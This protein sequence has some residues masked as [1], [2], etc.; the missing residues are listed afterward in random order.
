MSTVRGAV[1]KTE[2][3]QKLGVSSA[4][5]SA[6]EWTAALPSI[7]AASH[8]DG[9][10]TVAEADELVSVFEQR[11]RRP[12]DATY[13]RRF[14]DST[15]SAW[16][17]PAIFRISTMF[18]NITPASPPDVAGEQAARKRRS[19][20]EKQLPNLSLP[21]EAQLLTGEISAD[22]FASALNEIL[23]EVFDGDARG[24]AK[25]IGVETLDFAKYRGGFVL[26]KSYK[27]IVAIGDRLKKVDESFDADGLAN[28][29]LAD[30]HAK[31][32]GRDPDA[33]F[34]E[35]RIHSPVRQ[36]AE[37]LVTSVALKLG[38]IPYSYGGAISPREAASLARDAIAAGFDERTVVAILGDYFGTREDVF[39]RSGERAKGLVETKHPELAQLYL[40]MAARASRAAA[41][42]AKPSSDGPRAAKLVSFSSVTVDATD[43]E[44]AVAAMAESRRMVI[45][46]FKASNPMVWENVADAGRVDLVEAA[47]A[48]VD[49][50]GDISFVL[51]NTALTSLARQEGLDSYIVPPVVPP[52]TSFTK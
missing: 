36:A 4:G 1:E 52:F 24:M 47:F 44:G 20:A 30:M 28:A 31:R 33:I 37:I 19:R 3:P 35:D 45:G 11:G 41:T 50:G 42:A 14:I 43:V 5:G 13:L 21:T 10:L 16:T 12:E 48:A 32:L 46:E 18:E 40:R 6:N 23:E 15:S 17:P 7:F 39:A 38:R 2:G 49:G 51:F 29:W 22:A 9:S 8:T 25:T 26:P 27:E 34:P